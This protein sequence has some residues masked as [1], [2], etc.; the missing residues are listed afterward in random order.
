MQGTRRRPY[1]DMVEEGN[2]ADDRS[3]RNPEGDG[4]P[5]DDAPPSRVAKRQIHD[6]QATSARAG[7]HF[8]VGRS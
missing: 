4:A 8:A 6:A 2:A 3:G 1:V 5:S 7:A